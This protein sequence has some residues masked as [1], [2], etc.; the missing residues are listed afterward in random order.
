M[1]GWALLWALDPASREADMI[2]TVRSATHEARLA[3]IQKAT[4][5][6]DISESVAEAAGEAA[7]ALVGETLGR[8]PKRQRAT[9]P[10]YRYNADMPPAVKLAADDILSR[11]G[12]DLPTG[13]YPAA[14]KSVKRNGHKT[15][16]TPSP[17]A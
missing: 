7:R 13:G 14:P 10:D 16:S 5:A 11:A 8:A 4:E 1:G 17:K 6:V 15:E 9:Q 12:D 3:Q 2:A